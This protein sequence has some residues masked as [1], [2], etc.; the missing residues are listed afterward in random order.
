MFSLEGKTRKEMEN[1]GLQKIGI[2]MSVSLQIQASKH[3]ELLNHLWL[4]LTASRRV[5]EQHTP[6]GLAYL[7]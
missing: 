6:S 5:S 4:V 1:N 3:V 2:Y 7:A